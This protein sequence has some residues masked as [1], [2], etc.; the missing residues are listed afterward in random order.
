VTAKYIKE[1]KGLIKM[2]FGED[3]S[4]SQVSKLVD[5][6]MVGIFW[7]KSPGE[8][9]MF[10]WLN[11]HW[12]PMLGYLPEFHILSRGWISF[13]FQSSKDYEYI[14][15]KEWFWGPFGLSLKPWSVDFDPLKESMSVMEVWAILRSFPLD[16]WSREALESIGNWLGSFIKLE[17]NWVTKKD[18]RWAWILVVVDVKDRLVGR[19]DIVYA[20]K[21][22]LQRIDY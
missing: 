5:K 6:V 7:G 20:E 13:R 12:K 14:Q 9:A 8:K 10:G 16:F 4:V 22:W 11:N 17:Q 2:V 1:K 18:R 15:N 19:I 3:I 21:I